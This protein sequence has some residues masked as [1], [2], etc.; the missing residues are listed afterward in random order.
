MDKLK[1]ALG[2]ASRGLSA[3][4]QQWNDY[5]STLERLLTWLNESEGVLKDFTPKAT[6]EEKQEQHNVYQ[7]YSSILY[8]Y[9]HEQNNLYF[10]LFF[11]VKIS[12]FRL[13]TFL[14]YLYC[15][16]DLMVRTVFK[17]LKTH[18]PLAPFPGKYLT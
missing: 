11:R 16:C 7:V 2:D 10:C 5:E 8:S 12:I 6:L 1:G 17:R 4:L 9:H 14:N 13:Y 3:R 18:S 15:F